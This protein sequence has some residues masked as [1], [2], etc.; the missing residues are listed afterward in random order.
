MMKMFSVCKCG[1]LLIFFAFAM[2]SSFAQDL[3]SSN[4]LFDPASPKTK[5]T[6]TPAKK[7]APKPKNSPVINTKKEVSK[8][9][10]SSARNAGKPSSCETCRQPAEHS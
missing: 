1:F 2:N 10:P 6:K 4:K 7:A 9:K 8:P 5:S 3:G